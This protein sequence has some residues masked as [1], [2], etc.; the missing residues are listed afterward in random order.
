M[1]T[2]ICEVASKLGIRTVAEFVENK[3]ISDELKALGVNFAQG[4]Y[5]D[6]PSA[7]S[8]LTDDS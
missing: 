2:S 7:I 4:Y 1:V 5:Y 3:E 6:R 8:E